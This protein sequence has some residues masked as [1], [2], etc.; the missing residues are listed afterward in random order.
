MDPLTA[1]NIRKKSRFAYRFMVQAT[2]K[3]LEDEAKAY[4]QKGQKSSVDP[5]AR[6]RQ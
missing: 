1:W 6:V 3:E 2:I 4:P 5:K